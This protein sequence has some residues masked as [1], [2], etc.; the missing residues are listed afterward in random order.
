MSIFEGLYWL[1]GIVVLPVIVLNAVWVV[2]RRVRIHILSDEEVDA[3]PRPRGRLTPVRPGAPGQ[4][5]RSTPK[6][7]DAESTEPPAAPTEPAGEAE[8]RTAADAQLPVPA[9]EPPAEEP[10]PS[11]TEDDGEFDP[12]DTTLVRESGLPSFEAMRR[13][14][15]Q[16]EAEQKAWRE[17]GHACETQCAW[18]RERFGPGVCYYDRKHDP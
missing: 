17:A 8:A 14:K 1:A 2:A 12:F 3:A 13:R 10:A 11:T 7:G 9:T 6:D 4:A 5:E 15:L 16:L 18:C